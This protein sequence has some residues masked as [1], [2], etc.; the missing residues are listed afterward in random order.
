M[1]GRWPCRHCSDKA[2]Q[3]VGSPTCRWRIRPAADAGGTGHCPAT[4]RVPGQAPGRAA[5]QALRRRASNSLEPVQLRGEFGLLGRDDLGHLRRPERRCRQARVL[6]HLGAVS[7]DLPEVPGGARSFAKHA[8]ISSRTDQ[9]TA[10]RTVWSGDGA[11]QARGEAV[12]NSGEKYQRPGE[13]GDRCGACRAL[14]AG[15]SG[16]DGMQRRGGGGQRPEVD[17]EFPDFAIP[18]ELEQ[19]DAV[20]AQAVL[21]R[22]PWPGSGT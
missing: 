21:R 1:S 9:S 10:D 6:G 11:D 16:G 17:N 3:P 7:R 14:R 12:A 18:V 13:D 15:Q 8:P 2:G 19:V 22:R 5:R 20:D 4:R